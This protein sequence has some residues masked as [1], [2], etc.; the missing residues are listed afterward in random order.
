VVV[1][2]AWIAIVVMLVYSIASSV[3]RVAVGERS[4]DRRRCSWFRS[5]IAAP[6]SRAPTTTHRIGP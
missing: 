1:I 5:W 6:G 2:L 3:K 4:M